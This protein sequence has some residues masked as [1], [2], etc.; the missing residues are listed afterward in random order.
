VALVD[1]LPAVVA[2]SCVNEDAR[3]DDANEEEAVA[4]ELRPITLNSDR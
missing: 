2:N 1:E 4:A 3:V